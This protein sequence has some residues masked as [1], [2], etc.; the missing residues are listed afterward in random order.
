MLKIRG[1]QSF[2]ISG[3]TRDEL[4]YITS[5]MFYVGARD[6]DF[7]TGGTLYG[8]MLAAGGKHTFHTGDIAVNGVMLDKTL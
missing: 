5:S 6:I 3:L 8:R 7:T 1:K 4:D 2:T